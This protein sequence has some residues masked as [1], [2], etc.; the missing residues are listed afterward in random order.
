[1][2][3]GIFMIKPEELE[4]LKSYVDGKVKCSPCYECGSLFDNSEVK[5]LIEEVQ[6]LRAALAQMSAMSCELA[7]LCSKALG[8]K[9]DA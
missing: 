2:K 3:Y 8:V 6:R 9:N 7:Q 5:D 1:M 4:R